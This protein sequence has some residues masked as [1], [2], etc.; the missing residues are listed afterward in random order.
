MLKKVKGSQKVIDALNG[1]L[2]G[3]L[4]SMDQYFYY[5]RVL[6]DRG[7]QKLY[8]RMAH[9]MDDEK[10][11]ASML[12][13]RI[14]FLGG[15][16]VIG[17]RKPLDTSTDVRE[18]LEYS[19]KRELEIVAHVREVIGLCEAE[20]DYVTR[21]MLLQMLEDTEHDHTHWLEQQLGLIDRMG[22]ENYIEWQS[23]GS[24]GA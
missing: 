5:S 16:P 2:P 20:H 7:I 13:E 11:H 19:L 15:S 8:E 12:I 1:L 10:G 3:E 18:M 6:H 14:L 9:E 24:P 23:G 22:I 4:T 17:N 21:D